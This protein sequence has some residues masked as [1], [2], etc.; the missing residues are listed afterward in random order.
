MHKV[1]TLDSEN[2]I[3]LI[4]QKSKVMIVTRN[5]RS[6]NKQVNI[7]LNNK[8]LAQDDKL[9]YLGITTD[10]TFKFNKHIDNVSDK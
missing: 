1:S 10:S 4:S 9:K 2:K 3:I 5:K 7:F 6:T 8:T